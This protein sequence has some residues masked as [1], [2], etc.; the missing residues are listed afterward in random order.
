M[1]R[2]PLPRFSWKE[3]NFPT[4]FR[5]SVVA[6]QVR[7]SP[8]KNID[9]VFEMPER[10]IAT[11][12]QKTAKHVRRMVVVDHKA[13]LIGETTADRAT[14]AL[15]IVEPFVFLDRKTIIRMK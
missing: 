9:A 1:N 5:W 10:E 7:E 8:T 2:S 14:S 11:P 3:D 15:K 12:T 13:L 6:L 4:L